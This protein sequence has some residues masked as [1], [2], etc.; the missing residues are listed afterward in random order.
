M[1]HHCRQSTNLNFTTLY[2][3]QLPTSL[4]DQT[5]GSSHSTK[6]SSSSSTNSRTLNKDN[7]L[8]SSYTPQDYGALVQ[9]KSA[10]APQHKSGADQKKSN[11]YAEMAITRA[12]RFS[13]P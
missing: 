3:I 11:L 1:F 12:Y 5:M 7:K 6:K 13:A 2:F 8:V 9:H 4:P 10:A